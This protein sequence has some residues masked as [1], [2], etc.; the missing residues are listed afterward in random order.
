IITHPSVRDSL[1]A[2]ADEGKIQYQLEV[3]DGGTTDATAIQ[4][5]RGGVL[6]G[7]VSVP[8]RYIHTPVEVA[9]KKDVENTVKLVVAYIEGL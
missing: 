9:G 4:L 5:T 8:T 2:A 6:S 1:I 7:V 3:G